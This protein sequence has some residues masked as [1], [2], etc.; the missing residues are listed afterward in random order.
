VTDR[1]QQIE[2]LVRNAI[3]ALNRGDIDGYI[4]AT[5]PDVEFKSMIA[6]AEGETFRGHDGARRWWET[7]RGA[8]D[9]VTWEFLSVALVGDDEAIV[10]VRICGVIGGVPVEQTMWMAL[11]LRDDLAVWWRFYRTEDEARAGLS[12]ARRAQHDR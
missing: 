12:D 8:F 4:A 9:D 10:S 2:E 5:D 11:R 6:E 7:V 3:E 1:E